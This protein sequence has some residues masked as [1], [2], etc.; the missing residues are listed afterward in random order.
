MV[1]GYGTPLSLRVSGQN[2]RRLPL[3]LPF[4]S[5]D[6]FVVRRAFESHPRVKDLLEHLLAA[7][8]KLAEDDPEITVQSLG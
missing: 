4:Q 1:I 2:I 6:A 7:I 8:R 3:L 5:G